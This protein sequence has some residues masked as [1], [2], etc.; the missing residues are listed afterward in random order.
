MKD[1]HHDDAMAELWR[2]DPELAAA[3]LSAAEAD[4]DQ[5]ELVIVRRQAAKAA[6]LALTGKSEQRP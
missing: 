1:R 6:E 3:V 2:D 4:G 5:A